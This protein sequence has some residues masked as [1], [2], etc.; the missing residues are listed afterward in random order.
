[1]TAPPGPDAPLP[2]P[3]Q[4]SGPPPNLPPP[5]AS[6]RRPPLRRSYTD[7]VI[8]GVCGGLAEFTGVESFLWRIGFIALGLLGGEGILVYLLLWVLIPDSD[9]PPPGSSDAGGT[10]FVQRLRTGMTPSR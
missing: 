8:G 2:G 7:Y 9:P 4:A 5:A 3:E 10:G 1:M 6:V